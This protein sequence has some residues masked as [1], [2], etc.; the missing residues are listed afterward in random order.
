MLMIIFAISI[1]PSIVFHDWFA[2]HTD[3]VNK[4]VEHKGDQLSTPLFNC[5]CNHL[6]AESPFT[7]TI[8]TVISVAL[9]VFRE[10]DINKDVQFKSCVDLFHSLRGPP[11]A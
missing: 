1:T 2:N 9:P 5:Q 10:H 8:N 3:S 7:E 6:V 11:V 4:A